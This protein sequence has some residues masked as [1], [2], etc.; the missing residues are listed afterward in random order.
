MTFGGSDLIRGEESKN[1][2]IKLFY[3][4]KNIIIVYQ[5]G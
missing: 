2:I 5:T 4:K 3:F 1:K